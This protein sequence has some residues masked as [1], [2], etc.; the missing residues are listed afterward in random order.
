ME[1]SRHMEVLTTIAGME[2]D[3]RSLCNAGTRAALEHKLYIAFRLH[4]LE[5]CT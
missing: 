2:N 3:E 5:T 1:C 4:C